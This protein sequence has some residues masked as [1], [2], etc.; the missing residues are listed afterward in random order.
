MAYRKIEVD[1]KEYEYTIGKSF[2]KIKGVGTYPI[3]EVGDCLDASMDV[4][5][6]TPSIVK[7][8]IQNG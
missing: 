6:V 1:G 8:V 2:L 4:Y 3:H 5:Q 7:K